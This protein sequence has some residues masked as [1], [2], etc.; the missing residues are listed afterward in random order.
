[1]YEN[2][3]R[4]AEANAGLHYNSREWLRAAGGG[5]W[6]GTWPVIDRDGNI[7]GEVVDSVDGYLNVGDEAMIPTGEARVGGW[8]VKDGYAT[9]PKEKAGG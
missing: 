3:Q 5:E 6:N 8:S 1:M 4:I 9:P 7:T 2:D